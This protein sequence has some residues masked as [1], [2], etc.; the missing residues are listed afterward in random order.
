MIIIKYIALF[1]NMISILLMNLNE[2][3]FA[4]VT[5][6]YCYSEYKKIKII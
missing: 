4:P 2:T 6:W 3:Q 1:S 5:N